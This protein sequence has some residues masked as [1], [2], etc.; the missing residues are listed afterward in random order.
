MKI[1][2]IWYFV[3]WVF[4]VYSLDTLVEESHAVVYG[5]GNETEPV[6]YL[7][8]EEL[9]EL[10]PNQT[11]IDLME[12]ADDLWR[13]FNRSIRDYFRRE[14]PTKIERIILFLNQ[15]KSEGYLILNGRACLIG[16]DKEE[17]KY[18]FSFLPLRLE[19]F[20]IQRST[21]DFVQMKNLNDQ[22]N[23]LVVLRKEPPYSDCDKRN[24]RFFCLN[25]CFKRRARLVRYFYEANK[26][27]RIH[28]N[29]DERNGTIKENEKICFEKCKR[30]NCEIN[31]LISNYKSAYV[32]VMKELKKFG[33]QPKLSE[34]DFWLQFIGL[35]C[36]FA[37][38]SLCT[39]HLHRNR[40][41][42]VESKEKKKNSANHFVPSEVD[43]PRPLS[44]HFWL[45]GQLDNPQVQRERK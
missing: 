39:S 14:H 1:P 6:N 34:F 10:Y 32:F 45:P 25:D 37:S 40:I 13:H 30:E 35:V 41:H 36:S 7:A 28:L 12:L 33:A 8:C 29:Y 26:T 24:S 22:I 4:G 15:K 16:K 31:Q 9:K 19:Y 17:F 2:E 38:L 27:G 18:I 3:C 20:A 21:F 42:P 11:E 23:Q 44:D 43:H 5:K